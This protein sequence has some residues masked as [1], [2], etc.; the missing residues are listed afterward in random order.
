MSDDY[1][2]FWR[3]KDDKHNGGPFLTIGALKSGIQTSRWGSY[4]DRDNQRYRSYAEDGIIIT[5]AKLVYI[6][7]EDWQQEWRSKK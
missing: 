2:Y 6:P 5:R 1:Q 4:Y 7:E 3:T